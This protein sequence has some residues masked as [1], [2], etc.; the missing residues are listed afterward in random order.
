MEPFRITV[1]GDKMKDVHT[2][3]SY[4]LPQIGDIYPAI[5]FGEQKVVIN[6][7]LT[8]NSNM[9]YSIIV[10]TKTQE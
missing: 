7:L 6:R 4:V 9:P 5:I 2:Y 1:Y 10:N 8:A 3:E